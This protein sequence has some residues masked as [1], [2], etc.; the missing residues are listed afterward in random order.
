VGVVGER[1]EE[2][3][4][5]CTSVGA[6][7]VGRL[8]T[9]ARERGQPAEALVSASALAGRS[10]LPWPCGDGSQ[11]RRERKGADATP[12]TTLPRPA[13]SRRCL[14]P[15]LHLNPPASSYNSPPSSLSLTHLV[16][17]DAE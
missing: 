4:Q 5:V 2:H 14:P 7:G 15:T 8:G 16:H 9:Q 10:S 3:T 11:R 6:I 12:P 1:A 17:V 13:F